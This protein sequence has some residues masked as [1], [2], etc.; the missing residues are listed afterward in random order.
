[1]KSLFLS[2]LGLLLFVAPA[3]AQQAPDFTRRNLENQEVSLSEL[4]GKVVLINFWATWCGPCKQEL[5]ELAE[6]YERRKS[7]QYR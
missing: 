3:Q 1:M 7:R 4:R 5:P 2:V 6:L